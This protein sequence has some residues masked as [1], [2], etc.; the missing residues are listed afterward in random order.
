MGSDVRDFTNTGFEKVVPLRGSTEQTEPGSAGPFPARPGFATAV[1]FPPSTTKVCVP[2]VKRGAS[3]VVL[4]YPAN[5][6][7]TTGC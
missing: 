4:L 5:V 6:P 2:Q 7:L 3:A 1:I